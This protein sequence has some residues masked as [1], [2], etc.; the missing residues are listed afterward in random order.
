MNDGWLVVQRHINTER[1]IGANCGGR[2]PAQ[3]AKDGNEIQCILPYVTRNQCNT[4]HSKTLQLH[5][6]NNRLSNRMTYL[7]FITLAPS[8]IPSKIPHTLFN[9]ISLG[10]DT[11]LCHDQDTLVHV[12]KCHST[13]S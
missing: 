9:I 5:K 3:S 11:V 10:V 6:R 12:A 13:I 2:K 1:S 4:V 7:L 8:P